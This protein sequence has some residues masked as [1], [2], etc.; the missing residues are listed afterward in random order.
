VVFLYL[1]GRPVAQLAI[2]GT[3]AE[4]WTYLTTDHLGTPLLA[5]DDAGAM[6][7]EGGFEPFGRDYQQGTPAG[8]LESGVFLRLPGQWEDTSWQDASSGAG[9]YYN[10]HRWYQPEIGRYTRP[11]PL[12]LVGDE[13]NPYTYAKGG[14]LSRI[15]PLGLVSWRCTVLE[16]SIGKVIAGGLFYVNCDSGCVGGRRILASYIVG[17]IGLG[18]GVTLLVELSAWTVDDGEDRP[19]AE[20]L[21]GP[22]TYRGCSITIGVGPSVSEVRQGKGRGGFSPEGALG[23]GGG[24]QVITGASKL[25]HPQE[26]CCVEEGSA[27]VI[28]PK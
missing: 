9:I 7:W 23:L 17:G 3:V 19:D 22:F 25:L 27:P 14:P 12:G 6:V 1:A 20:N 11:D 2:D 26:G 8:A 24:C 5:T 16:A 4:T 15:D 18:G 28:R 21:E 13:D 10:V